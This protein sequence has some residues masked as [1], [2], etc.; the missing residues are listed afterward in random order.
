MLTHLH[1]IDISS[2]L[3][4]TGAQVEELWTL[5]SSLFEAIK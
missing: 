4:V 3:G 5:D 1:T 2:V